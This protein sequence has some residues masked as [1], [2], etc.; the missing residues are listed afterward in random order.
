MHPRLSPD[1]IGS[2]ALHLHRNYRNKTLI[3]GLILMCT[4]AMSK[5]PP[6]P[7]KEGFHGAKDHVGREETISSLLRSPRSAEESRVEL[8]HV[9][10]DDI[11]PRTTG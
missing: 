9:L 8:L 5:P 10:Q 4:A 1:P 3:L 11:W 7:Q 6:R 2:A